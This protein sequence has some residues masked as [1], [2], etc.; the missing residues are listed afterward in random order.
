MIQKYNE[1][2]LKIKAK[3]FERK[4]EFFEELFV[5]KLLSLNSNYEFYYSTLFQL[6]NFYDELS[7]VVSFFY[8]LVK[9]DKEI[10]KLKKIYKTT[11]KRHNELIIII[12]RK[13]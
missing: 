12:I 7:K 9:N 1:F 5:S 3:D 10:K 2:V 6:L 13:K 8:N 4:K 11:K